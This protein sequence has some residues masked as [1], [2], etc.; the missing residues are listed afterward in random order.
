[1]ATTQH[2]T[3]YVC[4]GGNKGC[5]G[6]GGSSHSYSYGYPS[7]GQ[8]DVCQEEGPLCVGGEWKGAGRGGGSQAQGEGIGNQFVLERI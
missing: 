7:P 1:M 5:R 8:Q 2:K 3:H 4:H 6:E